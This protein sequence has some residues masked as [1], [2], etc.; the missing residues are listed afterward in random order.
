MSDRGFSALLINATRLLRERS[1]PRRGVGQDRGRD[2][3]GEHTGTRRTHRASDRTLQAGS[4]HWELLLY[5]FVPT[6]ARGW[7][8][9]G[10]STVESLAVGFFCDGDWFECPRGWARAAH[11]LSDRKLS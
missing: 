4:V 2:G 9:V 1:G 3:C 10:N 8:L 6:T 11:P 7:R 5:G